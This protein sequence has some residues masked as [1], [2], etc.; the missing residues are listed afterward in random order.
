[1]HSLENQGRLKDVCRDAEREYQL[2]PG[3]RSAQELLAGSDANSRILSYAEDSRV[4]RST[5]KETWSQKDNDVSRTSDALLPAPLQRLERL[6]SELASLNH[7]RRRLAVDDDVEA[8]ATSSNVAT[9]G[10][11]TL[12]D[13]GQRDV[14]QPV[15]NIWIDYAAAAGDVIPRSC[16][17]SPFRDVGDLRRRQMSG[18]TS[19]VVSSCLKSMPPVSSASGPSTDVI[20]S[21]IRFADTRLHGGDGSSSEWRADP[22]IHTRMWTD[23]KEVDSRYEA[24]ASSALPRIPAKREQLSPPPNSAAEQPSSPLDQLRCSGNYPAISRTSHC[25]CSS[26]HISSS[27]TGWRGRG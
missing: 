11:T 25:N 8:G 21:L 26:V 1:M 24:A 18:G 15:N 5:T 16:I 9:T 3:S 14:D 12:L 19:S 20:S 7:A 27:A 23:S 22:L 4:T 2:T 6:E 10:P 13:R 17:S